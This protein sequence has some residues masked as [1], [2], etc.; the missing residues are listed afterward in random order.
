MDPPPKTWLLESILATLLCC[1]PF[2]IA[3]I[4]YASKV[5]NYWYSG[6]QS[7]A[8][9][10]AQS[11]RK[12]TMVSFFVGIAWIVIYFVLV[13]VGAVSGIFASGLGY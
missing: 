5:E 11:A 7:E 8:Q 9:E 3:G 6:R 12:W 4:V 2:G 13:M 1:L 10:A